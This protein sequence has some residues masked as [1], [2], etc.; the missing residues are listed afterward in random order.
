MRKML[1]A[2]MIIGALLLTG[3]TSAGDTVEETAEPVAAAT[4]AA[5]DYPEGFDVVDWSSQADLDWS[6]PS[7]TVDGWTTADVEALGG[8]LAKWTDT[9]GVS[10]DMWGADGDRAAMVTLAASS[11]PAD[12]GSSYR[13]WQAQDTPENPAG[14][15]GLAFAPGVTVLDSSRYR[16]DW[17]FEPATI[18]AP[19]LRGVLVLRAALHLEEAGEDSWA[20]VQREHELTSTEPSGISESAGSWQYNVRSLSRNTCG[21]PDG[22]VRSS[23]TDPWSQTGPAELATVLT[24]DEPFPD[25]DAIEEASSAVDMGDFVSAPC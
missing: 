4:T 8:V 14:R 23:E 10:D 18:E 17:K 19:A 25:Y 1:G 13:D 11:L 9:A 24:R 5:V 3:C 15:S 20:L 22:A 7:T 2:T 6:V 16:L 12:I 21:L